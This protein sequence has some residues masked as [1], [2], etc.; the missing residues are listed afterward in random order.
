MTKPQFQSF[1][2]GVLQE[3]YP[4]R[5]FVAGQ[6]E[7]LIVC[8]DEQ[9]GLSN[10][11]ARCSEFQADDPEFKQFIA[12]HFGKMIKLV[13]QHSQ[14][15]SPAWSVVQDRLRPQFMPARYIDQA[16]IVHLPL[17]DEVLIGIVLDSE[18]GYSYVREEDAALWGR[19]ADELFEAA[20][21]NLN[22]ASRQLPMA[23]FPEPN[24]AIVIETKDGYDAARLLLPGIRRFAVEKLG[25]PF[26]AGIPNRDFLI[27]WSQS[28]DHDFQTFCRQKIAEDFGQQDHPLSPRILVATAEEVTVEE[29]GYEEK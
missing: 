5:G 23:M 26:F 14:N 13:E 10:L 9:F 16:P 18:A 7:D 4:D 28:A 20:V 21:A 11:Y 15:D 27:M 29:K 6:A 12:E 3:A 25:E 2:L 8:G 1:V 24:L 19:T 22:G 17:G